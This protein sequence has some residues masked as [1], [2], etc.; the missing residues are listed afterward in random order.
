MSDAGPLTH[1]FAR[2]A[3]ELL[4]IEDLNALLDTA[5][6][7]LVSHASPREA[8]IEIVI[9][10]DGL[11]ASHVVVQGCSSDR[12]QEIKSLVSRGIIGEATA[13]GRTVETAN[14]QLDPRFFEL[15]SVQRNE[16]EAVLCVPIG[17][18][19]ALGVIYLQGRSDRAQ[20]AFAPEIRSD[21]ELLARVLGVTIEH[22]NGT[23]PALRQRTA[24][25]HDDAFSSIVCFSPALRDV[26]DKLRFAAPLDV[27]ILFTGPSG[28]GKTQL[29]H[30]AHLA[31]RRRGAPFVELNCAAVPEALLENELFGAEPGAHSAVP[32]HGVKGK[33][34]M[35]EGGT[36]FL[37]EIGDLPLLAQAKI[38]QLLQAKT[39]YRLG[40]ATPRIA[41][42]RIMAATNVQLKRAIAEKRFREDLYFRLKV[43]EVR[44]PSL[45]ERPEDVVPL[46]RHFLR[47]ALARHEFTHKVLSPGAIRAIQST[48]WNGNVRELAHQVETGAL[49]AEQRGSER[50]ESADLFPETAAAGEKDTGGPP[51]SLHQA[52]RGFQRKHIANV[53][54]ATGWNMTEAARMLDI[55][56]AH[57][58]TL[59]RSL[60][61][62]PA[63]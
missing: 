5:L 16:I 53:L 27:H 43:L 58:Y 9:D 34:E 51:R 48:D 26:V 55:S 15:E 56:R 33:V 52:T 14:A 24:T 2:G 63:D 42:V 41:D 61:L 23:R 39:Y 44:V 1:D 13:T 19:V 22:L 57:L 32:R 11:E 60:E 37:D 8:Y 30:A 4:A 25:E 28:A 20:F 7:L 36:L 40:S 35:A 21:V 3:L 38:L 62:K 17:K 59:V 18:D 50:V 49:A 46:A 10:D 54:T 31:S 47:Q 12:V 29:A 45:A 6:R